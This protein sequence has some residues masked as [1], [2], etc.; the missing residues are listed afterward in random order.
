MIIIITRHSYYEYF[1]V[2]WKRKPNRIETNYSNGS[3]T[4]AA[5]VTITRPMCKLLIF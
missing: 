2:F 1:L 5:A 3:A 4:A